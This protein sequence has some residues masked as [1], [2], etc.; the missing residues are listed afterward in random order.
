[1][2][3]PLTERPAIT[4]MTRLEIVHHLELP[5]LEFLARRDRLPRPTRNLVRCI[6][7]DVIDLIDDIQQESY[8]TDA[9]LPV[10][11]KRN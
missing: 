5:V 11:A 7:T 6:A 8:L 10:L 3:A 4:E 2:S 9:L 1:M